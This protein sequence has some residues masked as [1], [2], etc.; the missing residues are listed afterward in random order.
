[1]RLQ[2]SWLCL[3]LLI[4]PAI[5]CRDDNIS[6]ELP[7]LRSVT[8][9]EEKVIMEPGGSAGFHFR[10]K[11]PQFRFSGPQD[12]VLSPVSAGSL[13]RISDVHPDAEEGRYVAE[14]QDIGSEKFSIKTRLGVRTAPGSDAL[15]LSGEF[16]VSNSAAVP[17]ESTTGLP[18]VHIN[19]ANGAAIKSKTV[20]VPATM[21]IGGE[22]YA[23]SIRGR[24]NSTWE[25]PKKPYTVRLDKRASVMGMP[26]HKRWIL[27]ANFMDRT[28]MRNIVAMK[29]ASLTSLAWTPSCVSVEL[30]LNGRHVGNYLL[31]EQ[32]RVDENRV[33]IDETDGVL[34]EL[35][36][37]GDED[38]Q[39]VDYH[40]RCWQRWD[41]IP[42]AIKHPDSDE[43]TPERVRQIK[44]YV[45]E[46]ASVLYS[47]G[48]AD[49]V[50]G[51]PKYLD[52]ESFI[53][54]WIVFEVMG[55]HE[56]GNPGSV[57]MHKDK[58]GKLTAG[59]CWDFDWGVL[60]YK[61][62]PQ[63]RTGLINGE[64]IWYARLMKDPVFRSALKARFLELLPALQQIPAF[65]EETEQMLSRSADLNFS[66]WDPSQ[67]ASLNGWDII[68]GDEKL[69]FH[70]A[71]ERL[72]D[73][74]EERLTVIGNNL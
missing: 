14:L 34:L 67:D 38:I 3:L 45:S 18:I 23:C 35:D 10:V 27:L 74:F 31:I 71:C 20:W 41:G 73:I 11:D 6:E 68:N 40:G 54:Y 66:M 24:G 22:E 12:L 60:S 59:P 50:G 64:S 33:N 61:T 55:N 7:G 63:A 70:Q 57:F 51:Y 21:R 53:D 17:E 39:W 36:F 65:M 56:L 4:I 69:S 32:V 58:G 44:D 47:D 49:P 48:F 30:M 26:A 72:R 15:V 28:L 46:V 43:I 1:M 25:W 8:I 2:R 37:H 19:T 5:S 29:V 13:I 16:I 62:S 9:E 42:F 52:V